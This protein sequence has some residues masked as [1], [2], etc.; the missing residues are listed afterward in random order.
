MRCDRSML[1]RLVFGRYHKEPVSIMKKVILLSTGGTIASTANEDGRAVA[2]A[3]AGEVLVKQI[4]LRQGIEL[5]VKSVFQ[6]P[7][8]AI[9]L[10]DLYVLR[11]E[12]Q[13]LI[14][15]GRVDGI[16]ITHGTDTLEDTAYFLETT[17]DTKNVAVVVTGSQRV[18]HA[19]GT[20]AFVNLQNAIHIAADDRTHS[21]GVLVAFN[22]MIY[23]AAFVRKVSSYQVNGFDAPAMGCLG[24]IDNGTVTIFQRPLRLPVLDLASSV[25]VVDIVSVSLGARPQLLDAA[26]QSGTDGIIIDALG[27]GHV[28]PDWMPSVKQA[29]KAGVTVLVCSS[30]FHGPV[31]QSYDFP[32]SLHDMETAGAVG[33]RG[34]NA[35]KARMRLAVLLSHKQALD[36][37]TILNAFTHTDPP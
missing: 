33:I 37:H 23:A 19:M 14:D 6:K 31:H 21:M 8:N 16:V 11:A 25:P 2:G 35:R 12:C 15:G 24:L 27:R 36:R 10:N 29:I 18:P 28:P 22:E 3:L 13:A 4:Q 17:L 20:D 5:H 34:L 1:Q 32:G 26:V 7:S 30:T 9:T